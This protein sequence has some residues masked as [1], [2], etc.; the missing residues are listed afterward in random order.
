MDF[1]R[2]FDTKVA[3]DVYVFCLSEYEWAKQPDG[4]LSMWRGYGANGNGVALVFNTGFLTTVPGSPLLI[5][6]VRYGTAEERANWIRAESV[7]VVSRAGSSAG[8]YP[9]ASK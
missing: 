2:A 7:Q 1:I 5:S 4:L 3:T 6:R 9:Q 8:S